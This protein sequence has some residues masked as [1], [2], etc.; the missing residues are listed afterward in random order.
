MTL[1]RDIKIKLVIL[2]IFKHVLSSIY[3]VN[4]FYIG[5]YKNMM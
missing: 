2:Y 5:D 3:D 1:N 4:N